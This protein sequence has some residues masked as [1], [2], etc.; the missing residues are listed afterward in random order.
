MPIFKRVGQTVTE[1][2]SFFNFRPSAILDFYMS[3]WTTHGEYLVVFVTVQ[4]L[5]R[6]GAVVLTICKF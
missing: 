3:V 6:I 5:V 2:W 4:N 1:I